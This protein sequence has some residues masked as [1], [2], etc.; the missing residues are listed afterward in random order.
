MS[1]K[2]VIV[3][4]E[5]LSQVSDATP[6]TELFIHVAIGEK[7][8][9]FPPVACSEDEYCKFGRVFALPLLQSSSLR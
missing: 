4:I 1:H 7:H 5:D 3:V 9:R 2:S 6:T 8:L